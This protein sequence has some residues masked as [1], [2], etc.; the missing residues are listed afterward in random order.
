MEFGKIEYICVT[1]KQGRQTV[2]PLNLTLIGHADEDV[3]VKKGVRELRHVR[4]VRLTQEAETQGCLLGYDDL[5]ALLL[6]SVATLKRDICYLESHNR[7]VHLR[8][9]RKKRSAK[10][11]ASGGL[12]GSAGLAG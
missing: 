5:S 1:Q 7:T 8:G 12:L 10:E 9:R 6:T 4:I 11:T 2:T 3:F